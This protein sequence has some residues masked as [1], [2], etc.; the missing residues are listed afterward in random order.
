MKCSDIAVIRLP[1]AIIYEPPDQDCLFLFRKYVALLIKK[2][3][4]FC[5]L[6]FC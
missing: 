6:V 1:E 5:L 2:P 3:E 4:E